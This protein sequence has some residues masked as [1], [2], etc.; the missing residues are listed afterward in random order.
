MVE[1]VIVS[2]S[3][4]KDCALA[5]YEVRRDPHYE[6]VALLTTVTEGADRISMH[7][8]RRALLEE[9][10]EAL[11][12]R[13]EVV[14]IP[15]GCTND[16][17]GR[18]MAAALDPY[19]AQGIVTNVFGD[20]YLE[21]IRAFREEKLAQVGMQAHFPLWGWPT[22]QVARRFVDLGFR[23]IL[24][25]VDTEQLGADFVGRDYD[26]RLLD[27]FPA[28]V[29]PC[30]EN[31]EFHTFVTAGPVLAHPVAVKRGEVTV[32]DGRFAYCDLL[33]GPSKRRISSKA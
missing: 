21:D 32:W 10:A 2:W 16:E 8:V 23:A 33:P 19:R 17:Y 20:L 3:G 11:G 1:E 9:Q 18:R 28:A 22:D 25:C 24:T 27:E 14:V 15:P 26:R 31:G 4:G 6:V 7:G 12:H 29:D 30:G 5:L 13:L